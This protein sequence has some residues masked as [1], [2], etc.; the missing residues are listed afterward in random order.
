MLSLTQL[1]VLIVVAESGGFSGAA[2]RLFM[3]QPSVSNHVRNLE[4]SLGIQ[5]VQRTSQGARTTTAGEVVI[6]HARKVFE[7]LSSLEHHVAGLQGLQAGRLVVAGTTTLGTYLLPRLVAEFTE[8]APR[9]ECQLRVGNED[10]VENWLV[11]GEVAL[12][13]CAELP[14]EE[15]LVA[16]PMFEEAMVLVAAPDAPLCGVQLKAE[17]L[18]GQRFLM[19]EMGSAT[20]RQQEAA[21]RLWGLGSVEQW[22]LWGPDTLKEAV[23]A[24]L[25]VALLSEHATAREREFGLLAA[26]SVEPAPPSRTAYLVRRA[27]RVLTPPEE[28][29]VALV[30]KLAS[31]PV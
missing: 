8:Q 19:R 7:L 23:H 2:K 22:D 13:L 14:S 3:S 27:D 26:L 6:E 18:A 11:R 20:R 17:D 29:F 25:G 30:R 4:N 5:L 24:G 16:T 31:W 12:G 1:E 21:L 28:A 9:V 15:Q 10:A